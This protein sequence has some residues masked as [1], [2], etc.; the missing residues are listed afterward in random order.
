MNVYIL[1]LVLVSQYDAE[2]QAGQIKNREELYNNNNFRL[3]LFF[4]VYYIVNE[5]IC[6]LFQL[7]LI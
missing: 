3:V 5:I 1:I 4:F 6:S 7:G 2:E